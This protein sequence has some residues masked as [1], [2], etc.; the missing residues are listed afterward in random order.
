MEAEKALETQYCIEGWTMDEAQSKKVTSVC[1]KPLAEP[2]RFES[3]SG[4]LE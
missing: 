4:F 2:Y 3:T 1:Q